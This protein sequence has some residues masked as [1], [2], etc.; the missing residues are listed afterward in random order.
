MI[1][2]QEVNQVTLS[3]MIDATLRNFLAHQE[4]VIYFCHDS[5][6]YMGPAAERLKSE[7][8]VDFIAHL[9]AMLSCTRLQKPCSLPLLGSSAQ[10]AGGSDI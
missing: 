8:G 1:P 3:D 2:C 5:A 7:K 6:S 4:D 9:E 10:Q